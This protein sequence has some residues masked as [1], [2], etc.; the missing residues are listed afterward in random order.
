MQKNIKLS[1]NKENSHEIYLRFVNLISALQTSTPI[2]TLDA[3]EKE[4]INHIE[5]QT[6]NGEQLLVTQL[7]ELNQIASPATL[8]QRLTR[9]KTIGLISFKVGTDGRK[10][11]VTTTQKT[12]RYF[13]A[14]GKCMMKAVYSAATMNA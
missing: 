7:L 8:H 13:T 14:L 5:I 6:R 11:F 9:L 10:K 2:H 3:I 12:K 1:K 4:L